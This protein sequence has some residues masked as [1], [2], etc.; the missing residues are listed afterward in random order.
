MRDEP[1]ERLRGRLKKL[2]SRLVPWGR[3]SVWCYIMKTAIEVGKHE[4]SYPSKVAIVFLQFAS[5]TNKCDSD[6]EGF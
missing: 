4:N 2:G 6:E 1:K 5:L 3:R